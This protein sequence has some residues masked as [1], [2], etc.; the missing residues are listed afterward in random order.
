MVR[1]RRLAGARAPALGLCW[2]PREEGEWMVT[3][4]RTEVQ[5]MSSTRSGLGV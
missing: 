3:R 2:T 4:A 5:Q 1:R